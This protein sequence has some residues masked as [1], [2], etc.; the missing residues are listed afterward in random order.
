MSIYLYQ[1]F[2]NEET[3]KRLDPGFIPLDN[4]A[5]ERPDW[6]EFWPIRKFLKTKILDDSAW[7]GFFSPRFGLK[8]GFT[9][10]YARSVIHHHRENSDIALFT[11]TWD[12]IAYFKN[13]FEQGE[14]WHDGITTTA[15]SFFDQIGHKVELRNL[16]NF[17]QNSVTSNY[18]AA[19]PRFWRRWLYFADKLVEVCDHQAVNEGSLAGQTTY[20][21]RLLPMKVFIQERLATVILSTEPY[22]VIVPDQTLTG[23]LF[24]PLF[25]PDIRTRRLL[26]TCD[27]LKGEYFKTSE[28]DYLKMY[29]KIREKIHTKPA[30]FK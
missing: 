1:I 27:L 7:Y 25:Y 2:Y 20:G 8:T 29:Y 4:S 9:S 19:K 3:R 23:G 16:V 28:P 21:E 26:Q 11:S 14:E 10:E 13:V 12:F 5:S 22:R 6:F 15:Q 30:R 18:F 17:S 24:E